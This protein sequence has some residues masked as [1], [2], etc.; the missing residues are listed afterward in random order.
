MLRKIY[1]VIAKGDSGA[2]GHY[3]RPQD[4][5]ILQNITKT[6][7]KT[8]VQLYGTQMHIKSVGHLSLHPSLSKQATQGHILRNLQSSSLLA[9]GPLCNNGCTV[10]LTDKELAAIKQNKVVLQ[11]WHNQQDG[12]WDIPLRNHTTCMD[13]YKPPKAHPSLY[14]PMG[15]NTRPPERNAP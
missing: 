12:L 1:K 11:G 2:T 7:T 3:I 13:N 14:I 5:P 15:K 9:L 8:L 10:L 6:E 4:L